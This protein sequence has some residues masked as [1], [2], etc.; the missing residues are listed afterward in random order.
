[1]T[2][3]FEVEDAQ[4]LGSADAAVVLANIR[5]LCAK[6]EANGQNYHDG[7]YW[8]CSSQDAFAQL[9]PWLNRKQIGRILQ[10]LEDAGAIATGNYNSSSYDRTQWYTCTK[11]A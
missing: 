5:Y 4:R 9:F 1:M 11:E 7:S 6:N 2:Y 10:K 8:I 3:Q